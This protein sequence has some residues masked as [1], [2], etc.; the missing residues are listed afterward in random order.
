MDAL[1]DMVEVQVAGRGICNPRVL[2]ALRRVP[3]QAFVPDELQAQAFADGAL[4]IGEGQ[5][6]SQP[7]IVGRMSELLSP[8]PGDRVLEIGTGCGYQTAVLAEMGAR[9]FTMEIVPSLAQSAKAR[10]L[11][12]GYGEI[13]FCC[14]DG[15]RGWPEEAPFDGILV[16]AAP[17]HVPDVLVRQLRDGGHLVLPVGLAGE[18]EL[19]L[20][21]RRGDSIEEKRVIPVRFVPMTGE[22]EWK[23]SE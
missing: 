1:R 16:T 14:G 11:R 12:M 6:I 2:D 20:L 13:A 15:Y 21:T 22:A 19:C 18:Q 10:L 9:V 5:T 3:R 17:D 23:K 7:Y 4:P 8:M